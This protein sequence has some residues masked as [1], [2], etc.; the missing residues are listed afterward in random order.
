MKVVTREGKRTKETTVIDQ[1]IST[2]HGGMGSFDFTPN[3]EYV[4]VILELVSDNQVIKRNV[5]FNLPAAASKE[6]TDLVFTMKNP[7]KVL[8][9]QEDLE[10]HFLTTPSMNV[11]DVYLI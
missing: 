2:V 11:N 3:Q 7:T 1:A 8:D 4:Q 5:Q 9:N 6:S 10:L